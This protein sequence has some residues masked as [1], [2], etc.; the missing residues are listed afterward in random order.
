MS[1]RYG[2]EPSPPEPEEE[3]ETNE[4]E[5]DPRLHTLDGREFY[6]HDGK[7][8][9]ATFRRVRDNLLAGQ[10]VLGD[11][12]PQFRAVGETCPSGCHFA[13]WLHDEANDEWYLI[14]SM[15]MFVAQ[16]RGI[17]LDHMKDEEFI[18]ELTMLNAVQV[19][20]VLN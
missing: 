18:K 19:Q 7:L 13:I 2:P 8:D 3:P 12:L 1:D 15:P 9:D 20:A 14:Q 5:V 4:E 11:K 16:M 10:M 17:S 6:I